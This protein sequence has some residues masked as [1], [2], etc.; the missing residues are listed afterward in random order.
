MERTYNELN[1]WVW[2][3]TMKD[4]RFAQFSEEISNLES[5]LDSSRARQVLIADA[6]SYV[7]RVSV[8]SL[9]VYSLYRTV[10]RRT[11]GDRQQ[12]K[13][14]HLHAKGVRNAYS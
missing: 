5:D 14:Q 8:T 10:T 13:Q 2:L 6:L 9:F 1:L 4:P 11:S 12:R 3:C 7:S